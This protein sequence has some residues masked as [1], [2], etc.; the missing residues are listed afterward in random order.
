[1]AS[2]PVQ[3]GLRSAPDRDPARARARLRHGLPG[4]LG[5]FLVTAVASCTVSAMLL[6][7]PVGASTPVFPAHAAAPTLGAAT[8]PSYRLS[9]VRLNPGPP[10]DGPSFAPAGL[11][12]DQADFAFYVAVAPSSVDIIPG[13]YSGVPTIAATVPVGTDPFGVAYDNATGDVFV[14]NTGSDN[15]SVLSG[16]LSS[17]VVSI[18]VGS[19]P[20]GVAYDPVNGQVYVANNGSDNVSIISAQ[21]LTVVSSVDVGSQPTGVAADPITGN[22]YVTDFGSANLTVLS[23]STDAILRNVPTEKGPF[24]VAVDNQS[25]N[26]Y[27]TDRNTSAVTVVSGATW[28]VVATIPVQAPGWLG[29]FTLEGIAYDPGDGLV[30]VGAGHLSVAVIQPA[31]ESVFAVLNFDP[32][33][34]AV[35]P[36]TGAICVTNAANFTF[37]C[38]QF[39]QY[40][41]YPHYAVSFDET[42][43]PTGADW[44]VSLIGYYTYSGTAGATL[45]Y[46]LENGS[47]GFAVGG[48]YG[49]TAFPSSGTVVVAGA[50]V[51]VSV[52]FVP[53]SVYLVNVSESGLPAGT[54]WTVSFGP[55]VPVANS[56]G[57]YVDAY[58]ENGTYPVVPKASGYVANGTYSVVVAGA[59]QDVAVEFLPVAPKYLVEFVESGLPSGTNFSVSFDGGIWSAAGRITIPE[60]NG[61]Y[62]FGVLPVAGYV[63]TPSNGTVLVRG[64]NVTEPIA[65]RSSAPTAPYT[66]T[67]HETGLPNGTGW[68][69]VIGNEV[70][71][72]LTSN[73][74]FLEP[75]G[76]YGYVVLAVTGFVTNYSGTVL[77]NGT[78]VTVVVAF[79]PE[80][81][82]VVFVEFG[83]PNGSR[84]GVSATNASSGFNRT[85]NSTTDAVTLPLPNGTYEI[86][87]ELPA[88]YRVNATWSPVTVAGAPITTYR[89][90]ALG[91]ASSGGGTPIVLWASLAAVVLV[92]AAVATV[93]ALR[94]RRPP[95]A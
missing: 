69:V 29:P 14:T 59:S 70:A 67:F 44:N 81:Y 2:P 88:G 72:S 62:S 91:P 56:S 19:G 17:P 75:N 93:L 57:P 31:N 87:F 4:L 22:V 33:A 94:L 49:Y 23:G 40:L 61:N 10:E 95:P 84:W 1:M 85:A 80:S 54:T 51:N 82:P 60:P 89:V 37:E 18:P 68:A 58:L 24:D 13:N 11:A 27:V 74:T 73:V 20:L 32:S 26:V 9:G 41:P 77:V 30:W 64:A 28:D 6:A 36:D 55:H 92:G 43:L 42:G 76:S 45:Q 8:L 50:P 52:T 39:G 38:A 48:P 7:S 21:N 79:A 16:N 15:V 83:L 53:G 47:Y 25:D 12:Y 3:L 78:D 86:T 46:D 63:A 66:I 65:F 35:D 71:S 34:V 90:T 5:L